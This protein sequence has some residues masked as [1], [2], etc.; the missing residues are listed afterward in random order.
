MSSFPF[1]YYGEKF[2][3]LYEGF[4]SP[5]TYKMVGRR[6][7]SISRDL[8]FLFDG[9]KI[10]SCYPHHM[11]VEDIIF[12]FGYLRS[13]RN[14]SAASLSNDYSLMNRVF[15]VAGSSL[16]EDAR[17]IFPQIVPRDFSHPIV[18]L[19]DDEISSIVAYCDGY[20]GDN[21]RAIRSRAVVMLGLSGGI[22]NVEHQHLLMDNLDLDNLTVRLDVVKGSGSYGNSRLVP[23]FPFVTKSLGR[24]LKMR[25]GYTSPF[26]FTSHNDK[27]THLSYNTLIEDITAV[28]DGCGVLFDNRMLR[29]SYGQ[30]AIDAGLPLDYVSVALGH[31]STRTTEKSYARIHPSAVI[32]RSKDVF[33]DYW[34]VNNKKSTLDLDEGARDGISH[35]RFFRVISEV[36][37]VL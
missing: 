26:V 37:S 10:S 33:N 28:S 4:Y 16:V 25:A 5:L 8:T 9:D 27:G 7:R 22:R 3:S 32:S 1:S 18:H 20:E 15:R 35:L 36:P 34:N 13:E 21:F 24:Y 31:H 12:Y 2:L 11:S 29:R 17:Y 14:L 23:L 30:M 19:S 6:I